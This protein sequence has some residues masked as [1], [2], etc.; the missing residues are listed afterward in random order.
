MKTELSAASHAHKAARGG[1]I[2]KPMGTVKAPGGAD[3]NGASGF[4]S[5]LTSLD[6]HA[7]ATDKSALTLLTND[8]PISAAD[9]STGTPLA[10]DQ[11]LWRGRQRSRIRLTR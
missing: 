10:D 11:S 6:S 7:G 1:N 8:L 9:A 3:A 5:L 2:A 4:L